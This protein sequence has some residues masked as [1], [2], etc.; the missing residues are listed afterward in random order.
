[1]SANS[2]SQ[3][4]AN[5]GRLPSQL[6]TPFAVAQEIIDASP[7]YIAY[8]DV[9]REPASGPVTDFTVRLLSERFGELTGQAGVPMSDQRLTHL[10]P[11]LTATVYFTRLVNSA[12]VQEADAFEMPY[13]V[14]ATDR[15]FA[16]AV[17]PLENSIVLSL[18]DVTERRQAEDEARRRADQLRATLDASLNSILLM[19]AIRDPAGSIV[20]F[21]MLAA[22]ESVRR[23]LFRTPEELVGQRL[24]TVFPGNVESGFFALYARVANT[25]QAEQATYHYQDENDF[26][27]WFEVSAVR[28]DVDQIVLTFSNITANKQ[29]QS[30]QQRQAELLQVILDHSQTAISL[31][32][33]I[34]NEQGTIV[35]FKAVQANRQAMTNWHELGDAVLTE[36]FLTTR[37]EA[38]ATEEFA[39]YVRVVETGQSETFDFMRHNRQF[40][41]TIAKA[42][43]GVV[44]SAVDVTADRQHRQKLEATNRNLQQSN[45]DLQSFAYIASHDLQEPLRKIQQFGDVIDR[46]FAPQL[47]KEGADLI[48]RMRSAADRMSTLIRDLL[49]LS[50]ISTQQQPFALV[51]LNRLL[52]DV[53]SDLDAV[54]RDQRATVDAELPGAVWGD[55]RQLRQLLQNLLSNAFKFTKPGHAPMVRVSCQLA[56]P[57][58]L[59]PLLTGHGQFNRLV[60]AD[61]G[62][63]FDAALHGE[64]V[65]GAFQ[66]LHGR[67]EYAG[68]G[69]GL[70]VVKKVAERHGGTVT[71][72]SKPDEGTQFQVF[73]PVP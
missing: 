71:V 16:V 5:A 73:L 8:C 40:A 49:A 44:M 30:A 22:N 58:E 61:E 19:Q 33:A 65:F 25:G 1:M 68:T 26:S 32:E 67:G 11:E 20:D 50:R 3:F 24:L 56:T 54:V 53:L 70:A 46:R 13:R 62:I 2:P 14:A 41:I 55:E 31:H 12:D 34:R 48:R 4:N 23:S 59:P 64:R 51:D 38:R 28:S 39:R 10:L 72:T 27:G 43:G 60:V 69:I 57:A 6:P 9:V 37:P 35:D 18:V 66:R 45:D 17:K 52:R 36:S 15:W 63:G 7:G 42:D 29:A 47:G 21:V